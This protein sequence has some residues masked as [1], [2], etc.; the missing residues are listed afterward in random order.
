MI[1]VFLLQEPVKPIIIQL[2]YQ[3]QDFAWKFPVFNPA[4]RFQV[5]NGSMSGIWLVIR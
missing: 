4:N 3:T 5:F 1:D 2:L